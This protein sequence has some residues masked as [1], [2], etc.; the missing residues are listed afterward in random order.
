MMPALLPTHLGS[1]PTGLLPAPPELWEAEQVGGGGRGGP[2]GF[3]FPAQVRARGLA[4]NTGGLPCGL[5]PR[6]L[7]LQW[8]RVLPC[9]HEFHR[10]CVDPWLMLQQTCPLCKFNVL[11]EQ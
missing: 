10:D 8:L 4:P 11:G 5:S 3:Q 7:P 1:N 2:Q 9:K 6:P